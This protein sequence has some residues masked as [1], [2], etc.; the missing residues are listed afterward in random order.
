MRAAFAPAFI[1]NSTPSLPLRCLQGYQSL[2]SKHSRLQFEY[3]KIVEEQAQ[4]VTSMEETFRLRDELN[5]FMVRYD[6]T[7]SQAAE[8]K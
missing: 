7:A 2:V 1:T 8:L 5:T 6:Q 3:R 4:E